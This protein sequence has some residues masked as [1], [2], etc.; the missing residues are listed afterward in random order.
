MLVDSHAHLNFPEL[1]GDLPQVLQAATEAGVEKI[2][3]VGT[4]VQDSERAGE[5]ATKYDMVYAS[6]GVHPH[7][8]EA[9][10]WDNYQR[11]IENNR[12]VAIGEC[13]LDFSRFGELTPEAKEIE[14]SQ[15]KDLFL[16]QIAIAL[17]HNLPLIIHIRDAYEE[18]MAE[19][20]RPLSR[21]RGVFHCFSGTHDYARFIREDLPGFYFSFAGNITFKNAQSVRELAKLAPLERVLIE[22]DAP[23]LS[24]EPRRG[25][26]NSPANV[27]IV[28][29]R[30]AEV[31]NISLEEVART[32]SENAV[33]LFNL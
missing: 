14:I 15:Q 12:V 29:Q 33:K 4:T 13:G 32:T 6:V 9:V 2:I 16:R 10:N 20:A 22:T 25:L 3:C 21:L 1:A 23:F 18:I 28:A 11:L 5:V 19:F 31:K 27:K 7:E 24:P 8:Q 30:L 17:A 26:G